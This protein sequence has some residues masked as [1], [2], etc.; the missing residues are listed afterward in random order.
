MENERLKHALMGLYKN[1]DDSMLTDGEK[2]AVRTALR[3]LLDY[4]EK[5]KDNKNKDENR[6]T[7][8]MTDYI[9]S[10]NDAI[11]GKMRLIEDKKNPYTGK[12]ETTVKPIDVIP[13]ANNIVKEISRE[14]KRGFFKRR[15]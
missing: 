3:K 6:F 11:Q 15:R 10:L 14:E 1:V 5:Q 4:V 13:L 12:S 2:N 9:V 8:E 7:I